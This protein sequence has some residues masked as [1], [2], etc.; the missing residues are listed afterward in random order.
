MIDKRKRSSSKPKKSSRRVKDKSSEGGGYRHVHENQVCT[1]N[2]CIYM[3]MPCH[4]D[5]A[6]NALFSLPI[7]YTF[8]CIMQ[9][10]VVNFLAGY[11]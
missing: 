4:C 2:E 3:Y 1:L 6:L 9:Y 11:L 5:D 10:L 7:I 8:I